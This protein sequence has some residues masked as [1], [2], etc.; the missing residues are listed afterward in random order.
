M[1]HPFALLLLFIFGSFQEA[2][3]QVIDS[4]FQKLIKAYPM[5]YENETLSGAG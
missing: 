3:A 5:K 4:T 2:S 1:K